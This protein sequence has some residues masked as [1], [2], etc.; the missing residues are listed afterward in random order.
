MQCPSCQAEL[1]EGARFCSACGNALAQRCLACGAANAAA[2]RFCGNCGR[3]LESGRTRAPASVPERR[4]VTIL[5]CDLAGST[6]AAAAFDPEDMHALIAAYQRRAADIIARFGGFLAKYMGDGVLAYFGYPRAQEHDAEA[7][8]RA[9]LAL[10]EAV[11]ALPAPK[12]YAPRARVGIATGLVVVGER[13][14]EGVS[15]EQSVVGETPNLAARLQTVAEPGTVVIASATHR[16]VSGLFEY[17]NLGQVSLR[18]FADPVQA[19]QVLRAS[20]ID[21]RFEALH[22]QGLTP[23]VGREAELLLL[24]Q[25]WRQARAGEGRIVLLSGEP[26]IGKSRI[27]KALQEKLAEE[28]LFRFNYYGSPTAADRALHPI[29]SQIERAAGFVREDTAETKLAKLEAALVFARDREEIGLIADLLGLPAERYGV[30]Q[31]TPQRRKERTLEAL[32]GQTVAAAQKRPVLAVFEDAHWSDPTSRELLA[33]AIDH[34]RALPVM[35]LITARPEFAPPWPPQ[36][37]VE[38]LGLTRLDRDEGIA[39]IGKVAHGKALPAE[40]LE[41]I[42]ARTDGVPLFIE[43][44]TKTV[45][46][47]GMLREAQDRF[48][49]TGPLPQLAIPTTLSASLMARLDRLARVREVAQIGAAIGREFPHDLLAALVPVDAATLQGALDQLVEAGLIFRGG[50][51]A[52]ATYLFK[53]ALVQDAAYDTLLKSRRQELHGRIVAVLEE[54]FPELAEQRPELLADHATRAGMTERAVD[55]WLKAGRR[56]ISRSAMAE[57]VLQLSKGLDLLATLP[58]DRARTRRQLELQSALCG[59][60]VVTRG[61]GAVESGENYR[62]ARALAEE[63]GDHAALLPI[64]SGLTSFHLGRAEYAD[65]RE[66]A[67]ELLRV[68]A[69]AGDATSALVG[70]RAIGA[71]LR[72]EGRFLPAIEHFEEALRL[73]R[74]EVHQQMA[75]VAAQDMRAAALSYLGLDLLITG[76]PERARAN[77]IAALRCA[78]QIG[79]P[80]VVL[81]SLAGNAYF[82]ILCGEEA[83]AAH[84]LEEMRALADRQKF[85]FWLALANLLLGHVVAVRGAPG[86]GLD[87]AR[88]AMEALRRIGSP[89][90]QSHGLAV[91]ANCHAL[92]GEIEQALALAAEGLE[93]AERLGERW[94]EAELHR[95][96]GEWLLKRGGAAAEARGAF[97]RALA[98]AT[99]QEAVLWQLRAAASLFRLSPDASARARLSAILAR[100]SEGR[101]TRDV[102]EAAALLR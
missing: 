63:L 40:V 22:A 43:E 33:M 64:L 101:D 4:Q 68:A 28:T 5:F 49:L 76:F 71:C 39:L 21:N 65:A 94:F 52:Q 8:V 95:M 61:Q 77:T 20:G 11:A 2:A 32:L 46:E 7:A 75:A 96:S 56:S 9:G 69:A 15:Q 83:A 81:F 18:G 92:A 93:V 82:Y 86:K 30:P 55:Y 91:V 80:H 41:Q 14:G 12:G 84:A 45:L 100:Y 90:N 72:M 10:V 27:V 97:Q 3:A 13:I 29:I 17:R 79:Y 88:S 48:V 31:L 25:R 53:H 58:E 57:A 66:M 16:L 62:R 19:W 85:P 47:S 6:S 78:R 59:A 34:L 36:S 70:H 60:V 26:G 1:T 67:A 37:D 54:R 38:T 99:A 23:L 73:Y 50:T 102:T 42:L 44:L 87:L 98:I 51:G 89:Y 24:L 74:P 35:L